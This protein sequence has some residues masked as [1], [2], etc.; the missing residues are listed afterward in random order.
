MASQVSLLPSKIAIGAGTYTDIVSISAPSSATQGER[1]PVTVKVKNIDDYWD[2]L[3]RLITV[4]YDIYG[5]MQSFISETVIISS[6]EVHSFSGSFIM[7]SEATVIEAFTYYPY[8]KEWIFDDRAERD[9]NLKEVVGWQLLDSRTIPIK[10]RLPPVVGWQLLDSKTAIVKFVPPVVGWQ[11]LD[12]KTMPVRSGLPPVVG[13]QLLDEKLV[14]LTAAPPEEIPPEY[15]LIEH[16]ISHFAYIYDGDA[17]VNIATFK[18]DPFTPSAWA[19]KKF[20]DALESEAREKGARV[21][22]TKVYVDTT[23]LFWTDIR[24]EV[25]GTPLGGAVGA[26][27]GIAVGIAPWLA[28][29]LVCLAIIA[30]IVV[31]TLAFEHWME[32]F[33][34]K[35]GLEDVKPAWE[36]EA[37][38]LDIQD[39]EEYWERTPT[40]VGTLEEMSEEEL[41]GLLDK[42][43]E[44][45]VPLPVP[46]PPWA[47]LA[48]IGGLG[49]V[50]VGAAVA[51]SA[52]KPG[53][54]SLKERGGH[55][56]STIPE[57][58]QTLVRIELRKMPTSKLQE[59]YG[60]LKAGEATGIELV[61]RNR[62]YA[63]SAIEEILWERGKLPRG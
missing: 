28:I 55:H 58:Y 45:E 29:I 43:A 62:A 20:A 27:P 26:A 44:E 56:S 60:K 42:I 18:I 38:I 19:A 34:K 10:S 50:G 54:T 8:Y 31:A 51:L 16:T 48:L 57:P 17:E 2:H 6:L 39:A 49:V 53:G 33:K 61:E 37:L 25:T 59:A 41:R 36:K 30:V 13:W 46:I 5:E 11:L 23:P 52:A 9:V 14:S 63:I 47:V 4:F 7:P 35:P 40:P 22:E 1:V 15:E 32:A 3:I 12:S 24:I 21:L